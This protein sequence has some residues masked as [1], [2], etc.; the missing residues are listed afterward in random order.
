MALP[1]SQSRAILAR[2]IRVL[3]A[4]YLRYGVEHAL[5]WK[6]RAG[7][8]ARR[9]VEACVE[10]QTELFRQMAGRILD[11]EGVLPSLGYPEDVAY[12]NYVHLPVLVQRSIQRMQAT[13]PPFHQDI[14]LLER[15][16][17]FAL[18]DLGEAYVALVTSQCERLAPLCAESGQVSPR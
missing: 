1:V 4:N 7:F 3:H 11:L 18:V 2:W 5:T 8:D 17:E 15:N 13:L 16:A 12:L 6:E 9:L 10:E 14:A